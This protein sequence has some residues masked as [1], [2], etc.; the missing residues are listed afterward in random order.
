MRKKVSAIFGY[1]L[2]DDESLSA[3]LVRMD[4][5]GQ[6]DQIRTIKLVGMLCDFV[7]ENVTPASSV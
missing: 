5:L 4:K 3:Y 6:L 7:S 2:A 1:R